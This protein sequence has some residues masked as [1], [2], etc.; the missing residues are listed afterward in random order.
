M[1][2]IPS[3]L[4][5]ATWTLIELIEHD[6]RIGQ[7]SFDGCK[8]VELIAVTFKLFRQ[9]SSARKRHV[10]GDV[11]EVDDDDVNANADGVHGCGENFKHISRQAEEVEFD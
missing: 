4:S 1:A 7:F 6:L 9:S 8:L 11:V 2:T 3:Y 10:S 5:P